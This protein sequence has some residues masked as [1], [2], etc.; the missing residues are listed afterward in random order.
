MR[1][2]LKTLKRSKNGDRI[3]ERR[4][5]V[6]RSEKDRNWDEAVKSK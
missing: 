5:R 3:Q 6:N 2:E 1:Q 4:W